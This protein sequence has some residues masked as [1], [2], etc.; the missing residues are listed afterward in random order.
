MIALAAIDVRGGRVVQLV[1]G[2]PELERISLPAPAGV[3]RE[4]IA[5]GFAGLHVVDLDAALGT[6]SND[7]GVRAVIDAADGTPV[8]VGGGVRTTRRATELLDAGAARIVVGTRAIEDPAWLARVADRWPGRVVVAA[9]VRDGDVVV[10]GWTAG[11]GCTVDA[12]LHRLNPLPLAGILVTDVAREG[13][14]AGADIPRFAEIV[15]WARLPVHASGGITTEED[16][17]G[18]ADAGAAAAVLGM[19]LYTGALDARA[20]AREYAT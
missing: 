3:A 5:C 1:G 16:L 10:R 2:R 20:I 4:W 11:A 13:R 15:K 8:Q 7:D 6:G 12:L 17:A 14:M 19:S 9:D 18:L